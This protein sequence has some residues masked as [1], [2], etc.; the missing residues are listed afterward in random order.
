MQSLFAH[1]IAKLVFMSFIS[2]A[3]YMELTQNRFDHYPG[4]VY[5][6]LVAIGKERSE[7]MLQHNEIARP[8]KFNRNAPG[9]LGVNT[10]RFASITNFF[11]QKA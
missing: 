3:I 4:L 11:H 7:Y 8:K 9:K 10:G 5:A 2:L 6:H 1:D